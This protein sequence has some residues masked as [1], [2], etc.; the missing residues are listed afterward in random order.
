M[1]GKPPLSLLATLDHVLRGTFLQQDELARGRIEV[2][3]RRLV[4]LGLGL[5]ALYG[6]AL[7]S[8]GALRGADQAAMQ[9]LASAVKVPLL[10]LLTLVVTF[11]SLYVFAALQRLPLDFRST[12][13]LLLMAILVHLAVI[14]SLGPVF[15]FFAASTKSYAFM[16]LL[17]VAFFAIGGML[18]FGMLRRATHSMFVA[19]PAESLPPPA[20]DG[21]EPAAPPPLGSHRAHRGAE[22]ARRMLRT[23]CLV[24]GAVGAQM[25][26]L[27][28]PFLGSPDLPFTM[29]RPREDNFFVGVMRALR[30]LFAG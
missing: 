17:N 28:R 10:F 19:P 23:W 30:A 1:E 24:Y 18:G 8:Y 4:G 13:R 5:G 20:R 21:G 26:W 2:P 22:Q 9:I 29:F 6:L 11:P 15:A 16:L 27:L 25:G 7:G 14:A 3:T 12:L